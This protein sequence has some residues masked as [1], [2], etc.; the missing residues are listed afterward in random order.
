MISVPWQQYF[1]LR[2]PLDI[3]GFSKL[4]KFALLLYKYIPVA[5]HV[6]EAHPS[7]V[8]SLIP[9]CLASP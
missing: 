9:W 3:G 2:L 7:G 1:F 5:H 4:G 6:F 8:V